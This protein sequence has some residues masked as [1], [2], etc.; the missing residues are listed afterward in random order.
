[1]RTLDRHRF[2]SSVPRSFALASAVQHWPERLPHYRW[3]R[4]LDQIDS[5]RSVVE[6]AA[7]RP[8]GAL[9][10]PTWWVSE[11]EIDRERPAVRYRHIRGITTGMEVEWRF[12]AAGEATDVTIEHVWDGPAWPL[13]RTPAAN[14]IIGPVFVHGIASRTLSGLAHAATGAA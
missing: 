13:I 10:W 1:M 2:P 3:V 4:V 14:W 9:R 11:M 6:M 7:W 12:A 5:S 8:F